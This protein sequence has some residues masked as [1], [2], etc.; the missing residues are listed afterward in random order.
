MYM[1]IICAQNKDTDKISLKDDTKPIISHY[2]GVH[3]PTR[4]M[5]IRHIDLPDNRKI[6]KE[7][8]LS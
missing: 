7:K 3:M 1:N 5:Q 6:S 4:S 2:G 8:I